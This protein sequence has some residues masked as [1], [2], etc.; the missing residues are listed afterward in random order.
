MRRPNVRLRRREHAVTVRVQVGG[1]ASAC[2]MPVNSRDRM[3]QG[4]RQ[5]L[6]GGQLCGPAGSAEGGVRSVDADDD[7]LFWGQRWSC[8]EN[9]G[10]H[11]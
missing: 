8:L 6:C 11:I 7:G 1:R 9:M 2:E 3:Q 5:G 10:D 4:Q